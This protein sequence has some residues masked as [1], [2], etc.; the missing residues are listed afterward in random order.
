M[1]A[2]WE[3]YNESTDRR[4]AIKV[5]H[6]TMARDALIV[7]RFLQEAKTAGSLRHPSIVEVYDM[8]QIEP[9]GGGR[10]IPFMVME[11]LEGE[12][13]DERLRR[14]GK[15]SV[16]DALRIVGACTSAVEVAHATGIVHRDL[17]P[18]NIFLDGATGLPKI[19]DF[20]IS[21]VTDPDKAAGLT[22]TGVVVGTPSYMSP[23][24]LS[25]DETIDG[26][27][28][29]WSL[30]I[31]LFRCLTGKSPYKS[32]GMEDVAR[33]ILRPGPLPL[34]KLVPELAP[35]VRAILTRC[36]QKDRTRRYPS[37][38]ALH[39][40]IDAAL[41]NPEPPT[42]VSARSFEVPSPWDRSESEPRGRRGWW[43]AAGAC[44]LALGAVGL[45]LKGGSEHEPP[46]AASTPATILPPPPTVDPTAT[47]SVAAPS[48]TPSASASHT[49]PR[50]RPRPTTTLQRTAPTASDPLRTPGF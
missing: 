7:Q 3:A 35:N 40:A 11:L 49:I 28:D 5:L 24:Q 21:K 23:E 39:E 15:L 2:I 38:A 29:I 36:L 48:S 18:A 16:E 13:L 10:T 9:E 14:E 12:S 45:A 27:A 44:V 8:G 47:P 41:A 42:L 31:V 17:K 26:R 50:S 32:S 34:D 43:I 30:G 22:I 1:G 19:L 37:A 46:V 25:A 4:F 33:E 20:G 6:P